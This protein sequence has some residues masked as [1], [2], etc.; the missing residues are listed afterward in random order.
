MATE[1]VMF[2]SANYIFANIGFNF[3]LEENFA[4]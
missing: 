3:T 1:C 4:R 2:T